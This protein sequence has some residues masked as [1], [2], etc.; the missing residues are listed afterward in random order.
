[1]TAANLTLART[2]TAGRLMDAYLAGDDHAL[3]QLYRV[4][5]PRIRR[6]VGAR[7]SD[8][9]LVE[10]MVQ[11]TFVKA[12][13]SRHGFR[14]R[15]EGGHS[16]DDAVVAWYL[17]IARNTAVDGVR[18]EQRHQ[19]GRVAIDDDA[20]E[21]IAAPGRW[22]VDPEHAHIEGEE[23]HATQARVR[24]AIGELPASQRDVVVLHKLRGLPMHQVAEQLR[25]R[26]GAARVRAHRAYLS[27]ARRLGA[28][29][30]AAA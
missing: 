26:P 24:A 16:S 13:Q 15:G 7:I 25:V 28:I 27:L 12:H 21:V 19:R 17:A 8:P 2:H 5:A 23:H 14:G 18:S 22:G 9:D 4:V 29:P 11:Q 20:T 3:A 30:A 1:M 6:L 10:D